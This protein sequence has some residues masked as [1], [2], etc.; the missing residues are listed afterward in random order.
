MMIPRATV[1]VEIDPP[2][3]FSG[4]PRLAELRSDYLDGNREYRYEV[5]E[6]TFGDATDALAVERERLRIA[7]DASRT[8][9]EFE[10]IIDGD[11]EDWQNL[12]VDGL[13][14]GVAGLVFALNAT[15]C[16]TSTSCRGHPGSARVAS[17]HARVRVFATPSLGARIAAVVATSG[18]GLT[19]DDDGVGLIYAPSVVETIAL[20]ELLIDEWSRVAGSPGSP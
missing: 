3:R 4:L 8:V 12:A 16:V 20:A 6:A 9:E 5:T 19:I 11:L 10:D 1:D 14:I 17:D 18:C 7:D 15:G 2:A 13:D